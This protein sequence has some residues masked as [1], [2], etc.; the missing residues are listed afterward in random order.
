[1]KLPPKIEEWWP[2]AL[3]I[4]ILTAIGSFGNQIAKSVA[5]PFWQYIAPEIS[6][7][8]LLTL[9]CLLS[10]AIILLGWWVIYLHWVHR[11]PSAREF[12][13]RFHA[14]FFDFDST[15]GVWRHRTKPGYFCA[16]CKDNN[17]ESPLIEDGTQF[18]CPLM[19]CCWSHPLPAD[20]HS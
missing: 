11:E 14:Q 8:Q 6:Q 17:R 2:L 20:W 15:L 12:S 18:Q 9:C 19:G 16:N 7:K 13:E 5:D 10:L 4:G 1:M 3:L